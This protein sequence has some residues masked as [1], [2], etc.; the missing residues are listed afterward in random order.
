MPGF[1]YRGDDPDGFMPRDEIVDHFRAYAA[2]IAAPVELDTDV[3]RL[4]PNGAG[5]GFRSRRA[6]ARSRRAGV[7]VAG[8]PFQ[9][10]RSRRRDRLRRLDPAAPLA[11][12]PQPA[13]LPPGGV[14]LVGSGQTGV[15]LAEELMAAGRRVSMPSAVAARAPAA[16][17]RPD[18]LL[19]APPARDPRSRPSARRCRRRD[20]AE[21]GAPLRLQPAALGPRRGPR[22]EPPADGRRRA[23]AARAVRRRRRNPGEVPPRPRRE[24]PLRRHV[25]QRAAEAPSATPSSNGSA[26]APRGRA[27]AVRLRSAGGHRARPRGRRD[28]DRPLD[29]R[30]PARLPL[31]RGAVLVEF[32]LPR[33]TDGATA[34]P[35]L[36][37]IGTP[38]LVDQG[39]ANLVGVVRDAESF[40]ARW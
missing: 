23:P 27:V 14:L 12:L 11:R 26:S 33:Q 3:T 19:V 38:W 35:G 18:M 9:V 28:L 1:D 37:F 25:L 10:P 39:S 17:S 40:A 8:G 34:V 36:S 7:V 5:P 31:D 15:Q 13:A 20:A 16:L 22:H 32:G 2:A 4:V 30:L 29:L 24:P 21:P 6:A